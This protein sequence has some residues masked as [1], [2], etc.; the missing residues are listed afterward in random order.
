MNVSDLVQYAGIL[1]GIILAILAWRSKPHENANLD[2]ERDK[3]KAD[4]QQIIFN[5]NNQYVAQLAEMK[6]Q[7]DRER[8]DFREQMALLSHPMDYEFIV[9]FRTTTPPEVGEV[10]IRPVTIASKE[11]PAPH[12]PPPIPNKLYPFNKD[13]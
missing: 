3:N 13:K 8:M 2:S 6:E 10:V 4:A 1:T 7:Q 9:R 5:L 11:L 12:E